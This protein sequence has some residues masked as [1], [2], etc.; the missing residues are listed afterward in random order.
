MT[1]D[2]RDDLRARRAAR[3]SAERRRRRAIGAGVAVAI[4]GGLGALR[5]ATGG[6]STAPDDGRTTTATPTETATAGVTATDRATE[7]ATAPAPP[8]SAAGMPDRAA[9]DAAVTRLAALGL[10]V[11]RGGGTGRYVALTFDDGPGPYTTTALKAL[12]ESRAHATFFLVGRNV[13][14]WAGVTRQERA[15]GALGDHSWTHP[16]LPG[17]SDSEARSQIARTQTAAARASGAPV[18]LF[19]PPYGA[20]TV[21]IDHT[22][23]DLGMLQVLWD[24]DSGDSLGATW[25]QMLASVKRQIHPGA[26]VLFHENRGQTLK[27]INRLL[28]WL[29]RQGYAM[30]SV[31]E[32][33]VLDPPGEA[34][35]R[36]D[37]VRFAHLRM[38]DTPAGG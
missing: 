28:P 15:L 25:D 22:A 1:D 6:S 29:R 11:Y 23:R 8:D 33:L 10:P 16:Y 32:L 31:P 13:A 20:R 35:V 4:A 18:R 19:R 3:R 27:T 21:A 17:L 14:P 26:I 5:L 7:T 2:R 30:V 37:A 24:I 9:Q 12:R 36:A 34:Q 38:A